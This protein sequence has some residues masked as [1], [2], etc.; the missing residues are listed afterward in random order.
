M[1]RESNCYHLLTC[2]WGV[3]A[4]RV[5][6]RDKGLSW[7]NKNKSSSPGQP[8]TNQFTTVNYFTDSRWHTFKPLGQGWAN[9]GPGP[10]CCPVNVSFR[11]P[12]LEQ[13]ILNKQ[14]VKIATNH[15]FIS[16]LRVILIKP[17]YCVCICVCWPRTINTAVDNLFIVNF[18]TLL[19]SKKKLHIF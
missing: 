2:L 3:T 19:V 4:V 8:I 13:I 1:R 15:P 18:S 10:I 6:L 5:I 12:E 14:R 17:F 7:G 16:V 9:S 11:P